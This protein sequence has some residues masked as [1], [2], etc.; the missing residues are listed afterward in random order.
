MK[1]FLR[2]AKLLQES[3]RYLAGGVSSGMRAACKPLPLFFRSGSGSRVTDA[4]GARYIDYSLAWGPLILGHS[5]PAIVAAVRNQLR[6]SQLYGAQSELEISVAEKICKRVPCAE[7]VAFSSTGSE[8][9]QVAF[10]L[11]RAYTGRQKIIRFEGHYH[12]WLDNVLIGYRPRQK[13]GE[14]GAAESATEGQSKSSFEDVLVL[15][16]NDLTRL[17]ATLEEHK[18]DVAAIITEPILCN[19]CCLMPSAGYLEGLRELTARY[20]VV[21]IFDEV[22]TGFRVALG[23]AQ[24]L[25]GVA[26]D[27]ATFGKAVA[28][29]F[30]LS[31][32]AGKRE[33]LKLIEQHRVVH[34]GTFNGNPISLAAARATLGVLGAQKGAALR[35]ACRFGEALMKGIRDLAT[36]EGIPVLINGVGTAFHV[37]FTS[38]G[39]MRDYRD[40]LDCDVKARDKFIEALL[41]EGVYLL[42]DGRWY[43]SAAHSEADVEATLKAVGKVFVEH[44]RQLIPATAA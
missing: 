4:D 3:R 24:A 5:H 32:V 31:V 42:P 16:W 22:I 12:G 33:I 9:V 36:K 6:K 15:P 44:K 23:G 14:K 26:P 10:R 34:A 35:R 18:D 8:A 25:F 19:C 40:T 11:A 39:A 21:L 30:P 37:G 17:E 2:S 43:V 7:L 1:P 41:A 29:G 13:S 20:G 38:R 28:G 27:L